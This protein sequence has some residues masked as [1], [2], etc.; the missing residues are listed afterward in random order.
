MAGAEGWTCLAVGVTH[1][2]RWETYPLSIAVSPFD[3]E[4]LFVAAGDGKENNRLCVSRDKGE[5]FVYRDIPTGVHGNASG[6]G[7]GERLLASPGDPDTLYF[8]SQTGGLLRTRDL[9]ESWERLPVRAG[10]GREETNLTFVVCH[11]QNE[12]VLLVGTNWR[13]PRRRRRGGPYG[14]CFHG[15][16][17][18]LF[19]AARQPAPIIDPRVRTPVT[20]RSAALSTGNTRSHLSPAGLLLGGVQQLRR[21]H[22]RLL[23]RA[24]MR[25]RITPEGVIAGA[26]DVTPGTATRS[27]RAAAVCGLAGLCPLRGAPAPCWSAPYATRGGHALPFHRLRRSLKTDPAGAGHRRNRLFAVPTCGR[28]A[29]ATLHPPLDERYR[30]GSLRPRP[31]AGQQRHGRVCERAT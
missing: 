13:Q 29:T 22:G 28:A 19:R 27:T 30:R 21:G 15:R 8:A 18:E 24:L 25:Y 17:R 1:P 3:A 2:G 7:T 20:W 9:G 26:A 12:K 11:P 23:R 31:R 6:R 14:L 10:G 5:S 4:A 16:G